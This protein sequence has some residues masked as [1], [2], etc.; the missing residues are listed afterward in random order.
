MEPSLGSEKGT[1]DRTRQHSSQK[2]AE[3][4]NDGESLC[5]ENAKEGFSGNVMTA[6]SQGV[7]LEL[8]TRG[9]PQ[10]LLKDILNIP[11][12]VYIIIFL[13]WAH[14]LNPVIKGV[15]EPTSPIGLKFPVLCGPKH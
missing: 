1:R 15:P 14:R 6:L 7:W 8:G 10:H 3:P 4:Q 13:E 12:Y 9:S 11:G 5:Y 2:V